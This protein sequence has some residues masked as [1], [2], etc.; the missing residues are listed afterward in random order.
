MSE[1]NANAAALMQFS[2]SERKRII[3]YILDK[4]RYILSKIKDEN[5]DSYIN[6]S[7]E[8]EFFSSKYFTRL[9]LSKKITPELAKAIQAHPP[10]NALVL[11]SITTIILWYFNLAILYSSFW[12]SLLI[13][14]GL[15]ILIF[16]HRRVVLHFILEQE[17]Y[18]KSFESKLKNSPNTA[19]PSTG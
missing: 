18:H 15:I 4:R 17:R 13:G 5:S 8:I 2:V 16:T 6:I 10:Y 12:T 9:L 7:G 19:P 14:I 1:L 3:K 11:I